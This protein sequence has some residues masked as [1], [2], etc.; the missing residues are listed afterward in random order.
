M[1]SAKCLWTLSLI[2]AARLSAATITWDGG[3]DGTSWNDPA[4]WAGDVLPAAGDDVVIPDP[5]GDRSVAGAPGNITIRS[6]QCDSA[7][8]LEAGHLTLTGG[9]SV[10]RG[11]LHIAPTR[12]LTATGPTTTFTASG[13]TE[14][15]SA[16]IVA[17]AGATIDLPT[18]TTV[19]DEGGCCGA[20]WKAEG[21]GSVL[22]LPNLMEMHA[23][24]NRNWPMSVQAL[25]G[26]EVRLPQLAAVASGYVRIVVRGPDSRI[27]LGAVT[28][29]S[30]MTFE[31]GVGA[32]VVL[33]TLT[34]ID[35]TSFTVSSGATLELPAVTHYADTGGCCGALWEA[36]GSGSVLSLPNL[37]ELTGNPTWAM[38]IQ[39]QEGG[40]VELPLL[41]SVPDS[42]L[43]CYAD[44]TG[45]LVDLPSLHELG[46]ARSRWLTLEA[47]NT[48]VVRTPLLTDGGRVAIVLRSGGA[49]TLDQ[50]TN[51]DR[52]AFDVGAGYDLSLPAVQSL[53]GADLEVSD[54]GKLVFA[55]VA[56]FTD[57]DGC[58]GAVW[59][60]DGA[61]SLLSLPG[62]V[63]MTGNPVWS[64]QVQALNG[65]EVR[66]ANLPEIANSHVRFHAFG[67]GSL[68]DLPALLRFEP[69]G[70][71]WLTL[72][73][74][75]DG[76]V[77]AP[78]LT[79]GARTSIYLRAGGTIHIDQITNLAGGA[80]DLGEGYD[81]SL[82]GVASIDGA[83]LVVGGGARL[84]LPAVTTYADTDGCCGALW[85][86][87]GAGS[88][89]SLPNLAEL[90]GNPTWAMKLQALAGGEVR[91]PALGRI[92]NS[93]LTLLA[94][95][96]GS[97]IDLPLLPAYD[98]SGNF[99]MS[100]TAE[101]Q[102]L[103]N[104]PLVTD[105]SGM[106]FVLHTGGTA[107]LEQFERMTRGGIELGAG[108]QMSLLNLANIDGSDLV[109]TDGST[110]ELP[111]LTD[112]VDTAGCCGAL[113]RADGTASVL[114]LPNLTHLTGNPTWAM[115][116]Q[117][118]NGGRVQLAAL[119][120][121]EDSLVHCEARGPGSHV[122]LSALAQSA[123]VGRTLTLQAGAGGGITLHPLFTDLPRARLLLEAESWI[124][125]G[126]LELGP[127]S[128][129]GAAGEIR[130]SIIN[131]GLLT[132]GSQGGLL[133][134]TGDYAQTAAGRLTIEVAGAGAGTDF[135]RLTVEGA[136][137]LNG[138]LTAR[139]VDGF[140]A[141]LDT[142]FT[143]LTATRVEGRFA[144][145]S[146]LS[147][148]PGVEFSPAYAAD[149]VDLIT[150]FST[151]PRIVE[152]LPE[153]A[154]TTL[155]EEFTVRFS[156]LVDPAS[157]TD[158]DVMLTGPSGN[159]VVT[160]PTPL[161]EGRWRIAFAEQRVEG[162]YTLRIGPTVTDFAGNAMNQDADEVNGEPEDA[163]ETTVFLDDDQGPLVAAFAPV[164]AVAANVTTLGITFTE[165]VAPASFSAA[166]IA[167]ITPGGPLDSGLFTLIS[168]DGI[169]HTVTLPALMVE[170]LYTVQVG[171]G[172][173]DLAGTAMPE[174]FIAQFTIDK[175]AP[176]VVSAAPSGEVAEALDHLDLTFDEPMNPA[177]F[178][179]DDVVFTGPG[180]PILITGIELR[181]GNTH[182]L[183]FASQGATGEYALIVGPNIS[184]RA[185]NPM[186]E[187]GDAAFGEA[188]EDRFVAGLVV[189]APDLVVA[190]VTVPATGLPGETVPVSWRLKNQGNADVTREF[191]EVTGLTHEAQ[192]GGETRIA[193]SGVPGPLPAGGELPRSGQLTIP[194]TGPAGTLHLVVTADANRQIGESDETNNTA[195][196]TAAIEVPLALSLQT[197]RDSVAEGASLDARLL[198]NGPTTAPLTVV[199][200]ASDTTELA[201]PAELTIPAGQSE[202]PFAVAALADGIADGPQPASIR[203]S[204]A[205]FRAASHPLTVTDADVPEFVLA[206]ADAVIA[207]G[208]ST[209]AT[210]T[211][212]GRLETALAVSLGTSSPGQIS[213]PGQVTIPAGAA[214]VA[215]VILAVDDHYVENP[216]GYSLTADATGFERASAT[217]SVLDNDA[218]GLSVRLDRAQIFEGAGPNAATLTVQRSEDSVYPVLVRLTASETGLLTFAEELTFNP[219]EFV[220]YVPL[221]P[222]DDDV[223]E[224][225]TR[226]TLIARPLETLALDPLGE[227]AA[228][229]LTLLDDDGPG[230]RLAFSRDWTCGADAER[231]DLAYVTATLVRSGETQRPATV[232][233]TADLPGLFDFSDTLQ[234]AANQTETTF[235][236]TASMI[237]PAP[238]GETVTFT[239]AAAGY[240]S[241]LATLERAAECGPDLKIVNLVVPASGLTDAFFPVG[242]REVNVGADF[243][244]PNE[245]TGIS[246]LV[247][248]VLL[249]TDPAVG[250]DE[251][252]G[253]TVFDGTANPYV[254]LD[255]NATF[256]LPSV[257]GDYWVIVQ[258]DGSN[259]VDE[260]NELNNHTIAAAPL[261]VDPAYTASVQAGLE[262]ATAGT[263]VLLTGS[264]K[265]A[266][267]NQPAPFELVSLHLRLRDTE[268]VIA[269]LTDEAGNFS[270]TFTPLP[271]EAG[272][273][274]VAAAHPGVSNPPAQDTF[275]LLGMRAR[276]ATLE[277][278]ITALDTI[279]ENLVIENLGD[280]TLSGLSVSAI[281]LPAEFSVEA[282]VDDTLLPF[283]QATLAL[284]LGAIRDVNVTRTFTVRVSSVEGAV[285]DVI[286]TLTSESLRPRLE[287]GPALLAGVV[288]GSQRFVEFTVTNHGGAA[289]GPLNVL[290]P[291]VPFLRLLSPTPVPALGPGASAAISLQLA[292][293]ADEDLAE[294]RG[295]VVVSD[296]TVSAAVPY[297]FRIVS[298][299]IGTLVVEVTDQFTYYAE[300]APRVAG[301]GVTLRDPYNGTRL[302]EGVSDDRGRVTFPDLPEGWYDLEVSA[303]EHTPFR[304]TVFVIAGDTTSFEALM[305]AQTVQFRWSVVPVEIEDRTRITIE[306]VFETVVPVP[307]VT[308]EPS[309]I[310]L[311]DFPDGGSVNLTI[312]NHGLLAAQDVAISFSD[313]DCYR[314]TPLIS[315]IGTLAAKS[316]IVVPVS[317]CRDPSCTGNFTMCGAGSGRALQSADSR[318][319]ALAFRQVQ[320]G[321]G[322]G[323]GGG[324]VLYRVPCG[325]G[326]VGGSAPIG[327]QNAGG[328]CGGFGQ[329]RFG[330]GYGSGS[331]VVH[332]GGGPSTCNPCGTELLAKI[333]KCLWD[334]LNPLPDPVKCLK[335]LSDCYS[336]PNPA[337]CISAIL[338]CLAALGKEVP[339]LGT[340][341]TLFCCADDL[342]YACGG[343]GLGGPSLCGNGPGGSGNGLFS[344][345]N[346]SRKV[347]LAAPGVFPNPLGP[348][349]Y[350]GM[351][352]V[353]VAAL[354]VRAVLDVFAEIL[355]GPQW[356]PPMQ[357]GNFQPWFE[358]LATA[359]AVSGEDGERIS[360]SE[361]TALR[362]HPF[363]ADFS[364][365]EVAGFIARWNRTVDYYAAGILASSDVPAGQS[366]DFIAR[367]RLEALLARAEQAALEAEAA[368]HLSVFEELK[369]SLQQLRDFLYQPSG[370]ICA[371]V[372]LRIEQEAVI[373]RD[374]FRATLEVVNGAD[375]P[376]TDIAV[377]V[378]VANEAGEI[379]TP[380]FLIPAPRLTGLGAIDGAG[381]VAAGTTGIAVW[382]I[383]PTTD[384]AI[385]V[386][387]VYHVGGSITYRQNGALTIVPLAPS[388]ITVH[389][390]AQLHLTYFHE[391]DVRADDPFT[392][393][394]EPS[395]PYSL[396]V[397]VQN[398]GF[399]AARN[400]RITSAQPV[401]VDNEK[402]L[403]VD[404]QIIATEVAGLNLVPSLTAAFGDV[405]PG[406]V[407]IGRWLF[408]STLQG[409][410]VEYTADF[411]HL[412]GLGEQRASIIQSVDIKELIRLV[413]LEGAF[414][415][416]LPDMLVNDF[417]DLEDLPDALYL[418]DGSVAPVTTLISGSFDGTVGPDSLEV[419]LT[420]TPRTGWTYVRVPDPAN[421]RY[422]LAQVRRPDGRLLGVGNTAWTTDRTFIGGGK[423]PILEHNLHLLDH[424]SLG[425]YTLTFEPVPEPDLET[426][427]SA[428]VALPAS[429]FPQIPLAWTGTDTGGSGLAAFDIY[430][431]VDGG[432]FALWLERT[433]L[434]GAVYPGE[435]D[436]AYAFYSVAVDEAG[437]REPTPSAADATTTTDRVNTAP[438]LTAGADVMVDEGQTVRIT[439][440]AADAESDV[441]TLVFSLGAGAPPGATINPQTGLL[442]WPTG[443][444][445]G[446]SIHD[447]TVIVTDNGVPPLSA[448]EAV[449]VTVR[450]VNG[451]PQITAPAGIQRV[452][453]GQLLSVQLTALDL[454]LPANH[455]A[456][457]LGT[458]AP[459]GVAV[460]P[461]TGRLT[462]T[463][464]PL[465]GP[466]TN[467]IPVRVT[468]DGEPPL[469]AQTTVRVVVR[470]RFGD[471]LVALGRTNVLA[472][473]TGFIP[474]RLATDGLSRLDFV[475]HVSMD[476]LANLAFEPLVPDLLASSLTP[477]A[478]GT[479]AAHFEF[480]PQQLVS[481]DRDVA[482]LRFEVPVS[483]SSGIV[484]LE[485]P[486]VTGLTGDGAR[487]TDP[488]VQAGRVIVVGDAPVLDACCADQPRLILYGWPGRTY[489]LEASLHLGP[490]AEWSP[491]SQLLLQGEFSIQEGV[492]LPEVNLYYRARQAGP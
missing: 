277:R 104:L 54:G 138:T 204:A 65:G 304:Q 381:E 295:N 442:T 259:H 134:I 216:R 376:L 129:L 226:V 293:A 420:T 361:D 222:L 443:E 327:V 94:R 113:W 234:F 57:T 391:R 232:T 105:A 447:L 393:E 70:G 273:Y 248:R 296:E 32:T 283:D 9:A 415:D 256:R 43:R 159:I 258:A 2:A 119:A 47:R 121:I 107:P 473:N 198:R 330:G 358:L 356:L 367:D 445:N 436:H 478:N 85:R 341:I 340:G 77:N 135:G 386:P 311:A 471:F 112:Y 395:V 365:E 264:A 17:Q 315:D 466:S 416:G 490:A 131:H 335:G 441:Q 8:T 412:D 371:Q 339:Y 409:Q 435:A 190:D 140:T 150:R 156:E 69:E 456:F 312:T 106:T 16:L 220:H 397:M 291:P 50:F 81:L 240:F 127:G 364:A 64:M 169:R 463:P 148:G 467:D 360:A 219:G 392:D 175:T 298:D 110:L 165:P 305:A 98:A 460:D 379:V 449:Q 345:S 278:T 458:G 170:G 432:P 378:T 465:Q 276:P 35:G 468:D 87:E 384:T 230:L 387:T 221:T 157:F 207:E 75:D 238:P 308:V 355:G 122:E 482:R 279:D 185:G 302:H 14:I 289:S 4:N 37:V 342:S 300:G 366:V 479:F 95:G 209:T 189:R 93:L 145:L 329:S 60:A 429:S 462:W 242:F 336:E 326:G 48:G 217:V 183:H 187:D 430:V 401:I 320:G 182:R 261:R 314:I 99:R 31:I 236:V 451:A 174:A 433:T 431:S 210:L 427:S 23:N 55:S 181:P 88:V 403:F 488:R 346:S 400:L 470:D 144:A 350:P 424:D 80:L 402:G 324:V 3:G 184:D 218:P 354:H 450:E 53:D 15:N 252:L 97:L 195:V 103:I 7:L 51:F 254:F 492:G 90:T 130:A 476:T 212:G 34:T 439:N 5:A 196:S 19:A 154:V 176:R 249:S 331:V 484:R 383:L 385:T 280:T 388:P 137:T 39:A 166:D 255:R 306:A 46:D 86:A 423:R 123:A 11:A 284:R 288:P 45:S 56:G 139:A 114:S 244:I 419:T 275:T 480:D 186:N 317:I 10:V 332:P 487:L 411:E 344:G 215:F 6:L 368:G 394:V 459:D 52:G 120:R 136:A 263:P 343:G 206:V 247:Q 179:P 79:D 359:V 44:G 373:A 292:P 422:R 111:G 202:L 486:T 201:V 390:L 266:G 438:T 82:P 71:D 418:S 125:G 287:A 316:S 171:P 267:G 124:E 251:L 208:E 434:S 68:V 414:A 61:E 382:D 333:A 351:A 239:A 18:P 89:L 63:E 126:L 27:D 49:I 193:T 36:Q 228:V 274:T 118:L 41:A 309:V 151:G 370:G 74:R 84:T 30:V 271:G 338:D 440:T 66:L 25:D 448:S 58:C 33:D 158:A 362:S 417:P 164:G 160:R 421:G 483:A 67:E 405:V 472:G 59:R 372:R 457:S 322:G 286:L 180:G 192:A 167:L 334:L 194:F 143:F 197:G 380:Q 469:S 374:A 133:R 191:T 173:T 375:T 265:Q 399:G 297:T 282:S 425:R 223:I 294:F 203:A 225:D 142:V 162:N 348:N 26:G 377:E 152:V 485:M 73:A 313:F 428:V 62:L 96:P 396:A 363:A 407:R 40:R 269:A 178:T 260:V 229:D 200:A 38:T 172:V 437:N 241:A 353:A 205:G 426:P 413:N 213:I 22:A 24:P 301:A 76:T 446:P 83:D 318:T 270:A 153:A 227:G 408:K 307:V 237:D 321:G 21:P 299:R 168:A 188:V 290:L 303:A 489:E 281:G 12:T 141:P 155:L 272:T 481:G 337:A 357:S 475:I 461:A 146:D 177:S 161:G 128:E 214:S 325:T 404:F 20:A 147:A 257:P 199:L 453:E 163:F 491:V 102:G 92:P 268:R 452:N 328:G 91:L 211:R 398:T 319:V 108:Y 352:E 101:D 78:G 28:E 149:R 246:N 42:H 29:L 347:G 245:S 253:A 116:V 235:E 224:D 454:D 389:P 100:L 323:C 13:P 410:F 406:A 250:D 464:T 1:P 262:V 72:D 349:A 117:A 369:L 132:P 231:A 474:V 243:S 477:Q 109:V 233:L 115:R 444:G 285:A 310:D 455:L